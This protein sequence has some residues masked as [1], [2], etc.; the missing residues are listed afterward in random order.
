MKEEIKFQGL[1][2]DRDERIINNGE[3]SAC[4][5]VEIHDGAVRPSILM[6]SDIAGGA[7]LP[8][9]LLF[10]HETASYR[11]Y[12]S[13]NGGYLY[14]S[15]AN[16]SSYT[17]A[18]ITTTGLD[19][20]KIISVKSIGNTLIILS[21]NGLHYILWQSTA[22]S[23]KYLGQQPPF[24][25]L[26]FRPSQLLRADY[27]RSTLPGDYA[28]DSPTVLDAWRSLGDTEYAQNYLRPNSSDQ[29]AILNDKQS[30]TTEAVWALINQANETIS[31]DGHFYA[32]FLLRYCYRLYDG[33]TL[34]MHSAPIF[35]NVSLPLAYK[36]YS[37]NAQVRESD[38]EIC[39]WGDDVN[40]IITDDSGC[41]FE[42]NKFT[43]RY[44]PNNVSILHRLISQTE[45]DTLKDDW[46][47]IVKSIDI[48]ITP[49]ITRE[50]SSQL[51]KRM[52]LEE[53]QYGVREGHMSVWSTTYGAVR[54][55][56]FSGVQHWEK[57]IFDIPRISMEQY[58]DKI[59]NS[60]S[61]YKIKSINVGDTIPTG[62]SELSYDKLTISALTAQEKLQ[63]DDYKTHNK[64]LPDGENSG[65]YIYNNRLHVIGIKEQLFSGFVADDMMNV[66]DNFGAT[67][68]SSMITV[69]KIA[70][71]LDTA[72]GKKYVECNV[73][74]NEGSI[75][76]YVFCK[77]PFFYPD[78]RAVRMIVYYYR[79]NDATLY[80]VSLK[81]EACNLLNGAMANDLFL[82]NTI[83]GQ[84]TVV[85]TD[86][87]VD[88][89]VPM[90]NKFYVSEVDIPFY[91]PP[92]GMTTVGLGRIL[93]V[94]A[95]TRAL[96]QG[97]FGQHDL[98]AFCTDGIWSL[99]VAST[100]LYSSIH[101]ISREVCV[102]PDS[103]CQLDQSVLFATDRSLSR[104]VESDVVSI[105]DRLDG[106][107][108]TFDTTAAPFSG[109]DADTK[110]LLAFQTSPLDYFKSG[111]I[112][113]DF[114][115]GRV[116]VVPKTLPQSAV[117]A[118]IFTIRD[119]SW[120]T[121]L[122]PQLKAVINSYPHP[123]IQLSGGGVC[124]LDQSYDFSPNETGSG[125]IVTRTLTFPAVLMF[126]Q[127]FVQYHNGEQNP[128]L[129]FWGSNNNRTWQY[130]GS[131]NRDFANYATS[132]SFRFFRIGIYFTQFKASEK[133]FSLV[134][135]LV[136]KYRNL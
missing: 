44:R 68:Y 135:D 31:K 63:P 56:I 40:I 117:P 132:R 136:E 1:T 12:I 126:I 115:N 45:Y 21:D 104:V 88:D 78:N 39:V 99:A 128:L 122:L 100:G 85:G 118:Y 65:L 69:S 121:M 34:I 54:S 58:R 2:L 6:K 7:A 108:V 15:D 13:I 106:P 20:D 30:A 17:S 89:I 102:N 113:Y 74:V 83:Q 93:G 52:V 112:L 10:V 111:R 14:F 27:D 86:Y 25:R 105:S 35:M 4:A 109:M 101:P 19:V 123:Y 107:V 134:L 81:M 57:L 9:T 131:T 120:S 49:P 18:V 5:N 16:A 41:T 127:Q 46:S 3:L 75:P 60:D 72:D 96:S 22:G 82:Y 11:H 55:S 53:N 110:A 125:I 70:V 119:Q 51:I 79:E 103:I 87:T 124:L 71:E 97:Q 59:A 66:C 48:F 32:P 114:A 38:G 8:G 129:M 28:N 130:Y 36:V 24:V 84:E 33:T 91:F 64:L 133:Y 43:L 50:D 98:M 23:Y 37:C 77:T 62:W 47:D 95:V 94:A 116:F 80:K 90:P 26:Q 67:S 61:F 76:E 29:V 42:T 73:P 92:E